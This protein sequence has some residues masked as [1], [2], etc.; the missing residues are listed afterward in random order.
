[1]TSG[2]EHAVTSED[3]RMLIVDRTQRVCPELATLM[4]QVQLVVHT[5]GDGGVDVGDVRGAAPASCVNATVVA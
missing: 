5:S 4:L 1:M 2:H 3:G